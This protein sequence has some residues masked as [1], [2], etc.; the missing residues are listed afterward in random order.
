MKPARFVGDSLEVLRG[1]PDEVKS[2]IG[3]ALRRVQQGKTPE[4]AKPLKGI[5]PG[6]LEIISDFRGATFR[7]FIQGR[8]YSAVHKRR[9][10]STCVPEEIQTGYFN[11]K[12]RD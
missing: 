8:L 2:E 9:L 3:Y 1:L 7:P 12:T 4:I 6:A 5:A 10:R 11:P